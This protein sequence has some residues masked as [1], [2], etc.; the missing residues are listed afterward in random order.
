MSKDYQTQKQTRTPKRGTNDNAKRQQ[1][2]SIRKLVRANGT[3]AWEWRYRESG[4]MKQETFFVVDYPTR[5]EL[6]HHL[7]PVL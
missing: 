2:G 6:Q 1:K 3:K 4:K 7:Q 5:N